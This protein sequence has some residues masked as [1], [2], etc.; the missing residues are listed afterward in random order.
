MFDGLVAAWEAVI[1][2]CFVGVD[3]SPCGCVA[4]DE[5]LERG[6]IGTLYDLGVDPARVP[7]SDSCN[8]CLANGTT[9]GAEL[10]GFVLVLL[11]A[12]NVGL[13]NL[14]CPGEL[15]CLLVPHLANPVAHIPSGLLSDPQVSV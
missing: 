10:L 11:Q 12:A 7:V 4:K 1:G 14:D 3:G 13:I 9:A 6:L 15:V 8:C 2:R 5:I